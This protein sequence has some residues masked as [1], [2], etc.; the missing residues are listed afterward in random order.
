MRVALRLANDSADAPSY[1]H[2]FKLHTPPFTSK[3][4]SAFF[5]ADAERTQHLE[6]LHD[7]TEKGEQLLLVVGGKG[8]GKSAL[9]DKYLERVEGH[10][11]LCRYAAGEGGALASLSARVAECF[12]A[13]LGRVE[14]SQ[15][16]DVLREHLDTL[17]GLQLPVLVIDDAHALSDDA[18][19]M[20]LQLAALEGL[21]GRMIRVLLFAES[22]IDGRLQSPRLASIANPYRIELKPLQ[23]WDSGVYL[24]HRLQRA[25]LSGNSPFSAADMKQLYRQAR[26]IP[27]QLNQ[28]AHE[29][30][31]GRSKHRGMFLGLSN[32]SLRYGLVTIALIATVL[33]MHE[34][35]NVA[36]V[37][38]SLASTAMEEE[39]PAVM[40]VSQI[41]TSNTPHEQQLEAWKTAGVGVTAPL[42]VTT[43]VIAPAAEVVVTEPKAASTTPLVIKPA[44]PSTV[45][46]EETETV[47]TVATQQAGEKPKQAQKPELTGVSPDPVIGS[48]QPQTITLHGRG[49]EV[50][51]KVAVSRGGGV[52]VL[53]PAQ[54][55]VR[56]ASHM[57]ITLITGMEPVN[58]TV[59]VSSPG[60][61][62]SNVLRFQVK[63]AKPAAAAR[64]RVQ[65]SDW[66]AAQPA[67]NVTLQL[68]AASE[69]RAVDEFVIEH[70]ALKGP[71][72][73]FEQQRGSRRLY[74]LVQG[75]YASR[76]Q[77]EVAARALPDKLQPW[78]RD[79]AGIKQ[80][81]RA[82]AN[83][84]AAAEPLVSD[85]LKDTAWVWSQDPNHYTIQLSGAAD[86]ASFEAVM[87]SL[88][89]RGELAL[90]QTLR[91]DK[92]W[93]VLIYG[94]FADKAAAQGALAQLP[95]SLK[96]S[97]PW[98][99]SFS[100]LQDEI[101]QATRR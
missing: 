74:V 8:L 40:P 29:L 11:R 84:V 39:R 96:K 34:R 16:L 3:T 32:S 61:Q 98:I 21:G 55:T 28:V 93:Y 15:L 91:N 43:E 75:S 22:A 48:D 97:T 81:M 23:E 18:L 9:I 25:G 7:L 59:Q 89:L 69:E 70:A 64:G 24:L 35:I 5:Y 14:P 86:E 101:A 37:G 50:G 52:K 57:E 19:E 58:W 62:R 38:G 68:L 42:G 67:E 44:P 41:E 83:P 78:I 90:V 92:P 6:M 49:F 85:G 87:H 54:V 33:L 79:F 65:G 76:A 95:E 27:A 88:S 45:R 31:L 12:A 53:E 46:K 77:A 10:W 13:E 30:L 99:R 36:L 17:L 82:P 63:A 51:N 73:S 4:G 100:V 72:G 26:G 47:E 56:D 60:K 71:L 2:R 80:I 20:V 1:L 94:H 66:I